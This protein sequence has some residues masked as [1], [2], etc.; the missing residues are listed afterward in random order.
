MENGTAVGIERVVAFA[1]V[2][3]ARIQLRQ[4]G[5]DLRGRTTLARRELLHTCDELG[6]GEASERSENVV[7]HVRLVSPVPDMAF[8]R[9]QDR[10][11]GGRYGADARSGDSARIGAPGG[12]HGRKMCRPTWITG[13]LAIPARWDGARVDALENN[14]ADG[15]A[16]A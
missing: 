3:V 8:F 15:R 12:L 2:H 10:L 9:S 4:V 6:V 14:P 7:L 13:L 16:R 11:Y 1:Q 5:D